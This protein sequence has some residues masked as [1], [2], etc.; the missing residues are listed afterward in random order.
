MKRLTTEEIKIRIQDVHGS[1][2]DLSKVNYK[3][4]RTK[5]EVICRKHGSW[6]TLPEQLF[7]GQGCPVCGGKTVTKNNSLGMMNFLIVD[8]LALM[9]LILKDWSLLEYPIKLI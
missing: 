3:N 4:R 5:I 1:K 6:S 8:D 9:Y 2:Y 7:R